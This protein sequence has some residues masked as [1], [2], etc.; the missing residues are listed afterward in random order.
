MIKIV[1]KE[2]DT[3]KIKEIHNILSF[4]VSKL[5]QAMTHKYVGTKSFDE[6][7]ANGAIPRA[8]VAVKDG[9]SQRKFLLNP[10]SDK[11]F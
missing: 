1:R 4:D 2:T 6:A 11:R 8:K 5:P 10:C 3:G 7:M 9:V